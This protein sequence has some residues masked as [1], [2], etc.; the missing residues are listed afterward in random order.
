[1]GWMR[2]L[3][4]MWQP[5]LITTA[6]CWGSSRFPPTKWVVRVWGLVG[7]F[8]SGVPGWGGGN[9]IVWG[10]FGPVPHHRRY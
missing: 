2:M 5:P 8:W 3:M 6:G 4:S 1:M 7:R 9:R 10:W